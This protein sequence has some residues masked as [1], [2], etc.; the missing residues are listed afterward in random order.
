MQLL[1][2]L[3]SHDTLMRVRRARRALIQGL[4]M[5]VCVSEFDVI[6]SRQSFRVYGTSC[7]RCFGP[8]SGVFG[9]FSPSVIETS[10]GMRSVSRMLSLRDWKVWG[11]VYVGW[12]GYGWRELV[13]HSIGDSVIL[14]LIESMNLA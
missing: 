3:C 11:C 1:L 10:R 13:M 4:I 8:R 14:R 9:I 2:R 6:S 7:F 12:A 5:Q